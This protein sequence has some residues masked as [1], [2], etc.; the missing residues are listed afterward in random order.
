MIFKDIGAK[1]VYYYYNA[2]ISLAL[3]QKE[4]NISPANKYIYV[5]GYIICLLAGLIFNSEG[6]LNTEVPH[7]DYLNITNIS[8]ININDT[9]GI[10]L[11]KDTCY[12]YFHMKNSESNKKKHMEFYI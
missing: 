8:N 4:F 10:N 9:T 5:P 6:Y 1:E 12:I 2:I 11:V 7:M 3:R